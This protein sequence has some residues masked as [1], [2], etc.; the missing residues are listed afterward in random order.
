MIFFG[1]NTQGF[2]DGDGFV[3]L[4]KRCFLFY[5]EGKAD[6]PSTLSRTTRPQADEVSCDPKP[7]K[8]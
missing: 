8:S 1:R 4:G 2:G 7:N 5:L 3:F 6:Q